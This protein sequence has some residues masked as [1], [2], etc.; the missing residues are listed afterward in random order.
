MKSY[1]QTKSILPCFPSDKVLIC[2]STVVLSGDKSQKSEAQFVTKPGTEHFSKEIEV[3]IKGPDFCILTTG[4]EL[5]DVQSLALLKGDT[6]PT[7]LEQELRSPNQVPHISEP[8]FD[9]T[10]KSLN[11]G[12]DKEEEEETPLKWNPR[13]MCGGNKSQENASELETVKGT[14]SI[15]IVEESSKQKKTERESW[16]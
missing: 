15:T 6:Q 8:I 16:Y 5:V 11:I 1:P 7:L 14:P 4:A 2:T 10:P 3:S 9:Q 13:G 12:S